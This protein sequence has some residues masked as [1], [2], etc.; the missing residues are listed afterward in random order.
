MLLPPCTLHP[1]TAMHVG[2]ALQA[3]ALVFSAITRRA[4]LAIPLAFTTFIVAWIF[5][6]VVCGSMSGLGL[7]LGS[8]AWIF[9]LVVYGSMSGLGLGLGSVAWI[10]E[11]VVC[12]V[13]GG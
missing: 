9:E 10:F 2:Y 12:G 3:L 8:V 11:L 7:G 13:Q 5:E 6:L 4:A 1:A